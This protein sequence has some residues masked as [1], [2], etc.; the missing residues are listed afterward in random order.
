MLALRLVPASES[1]QRVLIDLR[2]P[3]EITTAA[4][5]GRA[6]ALVCEQS[7]LSRELAGELRV[8]VGD[9]MTTTVC[10]LECQPARTLRSDP[11]R[12]RVLR[13]SEVLRVEVHHP[14]SPA[15]PIREPR[16]TRAHGDR[17]GIDASSG[18]TCVWFEIDL[19]GTPA[20]GLA[21]RAE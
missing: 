5:A 18:A 16:T 6:V 21:V 3:V 7:Q 12:L 14:G 9:L 10:H 17:A 20:G 4:L 15:A 11:I 8:A 13:R 19:P 2:L 1:A